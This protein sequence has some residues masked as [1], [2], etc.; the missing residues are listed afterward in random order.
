V[1]ASTPTSREG[2]FAEPS[3]P[4]LLCL[5]GRS[6]HPSGQ[7]D[8]VVRNRPTGALSFGALRA[9]AAGMARVHQPLPTDTTDPNGVRSLRLL[10][11]AFY[12][13]WLV[14][15]PIGSALE[16]HDHG[17]A[18]SVVQVIDGELV[19]YR[20][21]GVEP[22]PSSRQLERGDITFG[23]PSLVH[24][25]INR[26]EAEAT[27]LHVYSPPLEGITF[28]RADG[29]PRSGQWTAEAVE[30]TPAAGSE[31]LPRLVPPPLALVQD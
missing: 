15:W 1:S 7:T 14:T 16:P 3:G 6:V 18:R 5:P 19:E 20:C 11:T 31:R 27:T 8:D 10:R 25:L 22:E 21:D 29:G 2:R 17:A 9:V 13:A 23:T 26:S 4:S 28:I 12:D 24:E 30:P